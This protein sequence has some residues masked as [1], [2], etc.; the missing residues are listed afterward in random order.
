MS[1]K[2][3]R[4]TKMIL[5]L[6]AESTEKQPHINRLFD[7]MHGLTTLYKVRLTNEK[8]LYT[9]YIQESCQK[10]V[11]ILFNQV[12]LENRAFCECV[13]TLLAAKLNVIG[14]LDELM[15]KERVLSTFSFNNKRKQ[16][17]ED[18]VTKAISFEKGKLFRAAPLVERINNVCCHSTAQNNATKSPS[19]KRFPAKITSKL[20]PDLL[21][22]LNSQK[23]VL[24]KPVTKQPRK[25]S[26][27]CSSMSKHNQ[28]KFPPLATSAKQKSRDSTRDSKSRSTGRTVNRKTDMPQHDSSSSS[29]NTNG[30]RKRITLSTISP[31]KEPTNSSPV[32]ATKSHRLTCPTIQISQE[33]D[34]NTE[35]TTT[36]PENNMPWSLSSKCKESCFSSAN[37]GDPDVDATSL[38]SLIHI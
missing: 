34:G 12:G 2:F 30:T 31:L 20:Q 33:D 16:L 21:A 1:S 10:L 4:N 17:L 8:T 15:S 36:T 18:I 38:L 7:I 19:N 3:G 23:V 11:V 24:V 22:C 27:S 14:I 13:R 29:P 35:P 6:V 32:V 9:A 5:F 37:D 25:P 26:P 28:I